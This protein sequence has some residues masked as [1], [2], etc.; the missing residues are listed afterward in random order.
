MPS[1]TPTAAADNGTRCSD[2]AFIPDP[3]THD[4]RLA[5]KARMFGQMQTDT[6]QHRRQGS[7]NTNSVLPR[8]GRS[9]G[10]RA[11]KCADVPPVPVPTAMYCRPSTA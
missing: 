11:L 5:R 1:S 2:P 7:V 9:S 10:V 4:N 6:D 8:L 3:G